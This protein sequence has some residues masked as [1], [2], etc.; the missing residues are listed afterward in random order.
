VKPNK[1]IPEKLK[2]DMVTF[3]TKIVNKYSITAL[4]R[5]ENKPIV[6]KL[7]GKVSMLNIGLRIKNISVKVIPP[8]NND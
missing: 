6:I 4:T 5:T 1:D 7:K 2:A 8:I 3:G